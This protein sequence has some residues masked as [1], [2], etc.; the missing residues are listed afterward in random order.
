MEK[1]TAF[2]VCID[3]FV[4]PPKTPLSVI[5]DALEDIG[6]ERSEDVRGAFG[7]LG[8][9]AKY[10]AEDDGLIRQLTIAL[11][12]DDQ[13][14]AVDVAS[15]IVKRGI[16]VELEHQEHAWA[17][18]DSD[19]P[20]LYLTRYYSLLLYMAHGRQSY[21][22]DHSVRGRYAGDEWTVMDYGT[23][24]EYNSALRDVL[25]I[26]RIVVPTPDI[27][28]PTAPP[29][30]SPTEA[31]GISGSFRV[32]VE[33]RTRY[34]L[35]GEYRVV[36]YYSGDSDPDELLRWWTMFSPTVYRNSPGSGD[37]YVWIEQNQDGTWVALDY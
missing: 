18:L 24:N 21:S 31:S 35:H 17:G 6:D 32:C 29:A 26:F 9:P 8:L 11:R 5:A 30:I 27:P 12:R 25:R 33:H 7:T 13:E 37:W 16:R 2:S 23:G 22:W 20:S 34:G 36:G 10:C 15:E 4:F 28:A 3:G 19:D 1:V 14:V